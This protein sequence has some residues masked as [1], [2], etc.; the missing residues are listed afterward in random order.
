M[1]QLSE[2]LQQLQ[3]TLR[4]EEVRSRGCWL[5]RACSFWGW[6]NG[7]A[8]SA[9]LLVLYLAYRRL[10]ICCLVGS[11]DPNATVGNVSQG[12]GHPPI[13]IHD[14]VLGAYCYSPSQPVI[15]TFAQVKIH[16]SRYTLLLGGNNL[17]CPP[18]AEY[19]ET[20]V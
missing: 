11:E 14:C 4:W 20:E 19:L 6:C 18:I 9:F 7:N 15:G 10:S 16:V 17:W 5:Q 2:K 12:G 3:P 13:L 1:N 8:A